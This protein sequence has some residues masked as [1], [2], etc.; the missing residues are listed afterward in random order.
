M[1]SVFQLANEI[2]LLNY[3]QSHQKRG[4]EIVFQSRAPRRIIP[5]KGEEAT[6]EENCTVGSDIIF[7][8]LR[9]SAV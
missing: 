1:I 2:P 9:F 8:F 7:Y 6:G 5:F 4:A 3:P